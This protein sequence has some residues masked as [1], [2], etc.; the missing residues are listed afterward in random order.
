LASVSSISTELVTPR[1][2]PSSAADAFFAYSYLYKQAAYSCYSNSA[3]SPRRQTYTTPRLS[4]VSTYTR[5]ESDMAYNPVDPRDQIYYQ[6]PGSYIQSQGGYELRS[7][8]PSFTSY[9]GSFISQNTIPNDAASDHQ[10]LLQG[11]NQPSQQGA[12]WKPGFWR[13]FPVLAILSI[14]GVLASNSTNDVLKLASH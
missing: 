7:V 4:L 10:H 13:R 6:N 3:A 1:P 11:P 12:P 8:A 2:T 9:K 5:H 14:L